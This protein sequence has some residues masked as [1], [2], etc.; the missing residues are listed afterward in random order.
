V[1][2]DDEGTPLGDATEPV[3]FDSI[4]D[5]MEL[6]TEAPT[7]EIILDE[8]TPLAD[9]LPQTGQASPELFYGFGSIVSALGIYLKRKIK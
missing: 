3:N 8:E 4:Y 6:T 7:D 9:A 2:I 1:V 5:N